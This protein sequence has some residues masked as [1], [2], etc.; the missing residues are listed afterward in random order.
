MN[1]QDLPQL[2][3]ARTGEPVALPPEHLGPALASGQV[4]FMK[5]ARIPVVSPDG[6]PGTIDASEAHHALTGGYQLDT[7]ELQAER[8]K[9]AEFGNRP[10]AAGIAGAARGAT[11]GISDQALTRSGL[12]EP[13]TLAELEKRNPGASITGEIAGAVAPL[14]LSGGSSGAAS[15]ARLAPPSLLAKAGSAVTEAL[16]SKGGAEAAKSLGK[17]IASTVVPRMAGS[18]V[19]GAAY[20]VGHVISEQAL[21]DPGLS[22]EK[23]L[24]QIG[25]STVLGAGLG[26]LFGGVEAALPAPGVAGA[27]KTGQ[28][29][30]TATAEAAAA[31][32]A[33]GT[34]G[35][36]LAQ[37]EISAEARHGILEGLQ[38]LKPN[39]EEIVAAARAIDAPV[40]ESQISA[41]KHVQD[42][43]SV[44]MQSP[45]PV[46]VARQQLLQKGID[47][48]ELA[49]SRS[50]GD[51]VPLSQA[52]VG[53][54]LRRSLTEKFEAEYAPI[55]SLYD[56][57]G[58]TTQAIPVPQASVKAI[59][60]NIR[61]LEDV[62]LSPS[63][64]EAR[65]ANRVADEIENIQTVDQIKKYRS[66][67]NRS[68]ELEA[69]H[70]KGVLVD[71][72]NDLEENVVR[73]FARDQMRTPEAKS[74]IEGL[75]GKM[76]VA[77][78]GYRG[79]RE[80]MAEF[81]DVLGKKKI[82]GPQDFI[83]FLADATP[84][85]LTQKLFAKNNSK[86]LDFLSREFPDE[87]RILVD[88]Q[89]AELRAAATKDGVLQVN[90]VLRNVAKLEPEV[91]RLMFSPAEL[92]QIEA[93]KTYMEA[94]PKNVNPSGTSKAEAYRRF[95]SNPIAA[96]AESSRDLAMREAMKRLVDKTGGA[97]AS[98]IQTLIRLER[99]SQETTR[100]IRSAIRGFIRS[101][102]SA[103]KKATIP[104][105]IEV[106][107]GVN[108]SGEKY[109]RA[110]AGKKDAYEKRMDEVSNTLANPEALVERLTRALK[111]VLDAAPGIGQGIQETI[112]RALQFLYDKA[113][114]DPSPGK[115]LSPKLRR[116]RPSDSEV[117][118]WERYVAAIEKPMTV[119]DDFRHG[120]VS[121]EG[122]EAIR[123]V[124]PK[125]FQEI[126]GQLTEHLAELRE[127]LPYKKRLQVSI[128]FGVPVE[129]AMEPAFLAYMQQLHAQSAASDAAADGGAVRTT[130]GALGK[131]SHANQVQTDTQRLLNRRSL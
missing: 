22:A 118:Q 24:S 27:T 98:K 119:L 51:G 99:M 127:D 67:L 35:N 50:L 129:S 38:Q 100:Q 69:R 59:A 39:S 75:L 84:E 110:P 102:A 92:A 25:L 77:K 86:F 18:A 122:V 124:Y 91:Q 8:A 79:L 10:I 28:E 16:A 73:R 34:L 83:D 31:P 60:R 81:G 3:D 87:L 43:D 76:D 71:K 114:K 66:I 46:G 108:F 53:E 104:A 21:G 63:S 94:L 44:L 88:Y 11:F 126:T 64:A 62:R 117:A 101:E 17:R 95:F 12:V 19:E 4:G 23:A 113:P 65:L 7:P 14:V 97:D 111:P 70:M 82:H 125:S 116:Y 56:E 128:L 93:A 33:D 1:I 130:A 40:L 41:S 58:A 90:Q 13:E 32:V 78:A 74:R 30:G 109:L 68:T 2:Y 103:G 54:S 131:I 123:A 52:E 15:A 115:I 9:Q 120:R 121:Y 55:Q 26:A 5:G 29:A 20:G 57:L 107:H 105:S 85:K 112:Q 42:W 80:R 47:R 96:A 48:A 72:L 6:V 36:A 37:A 49:V 45:T 106:L 89:K 61:A